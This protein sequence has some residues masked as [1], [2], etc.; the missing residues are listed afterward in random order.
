LRK[1]AR[2]ENDVEIYQNQKEIIQG[3]RQ[4]RNQV[5]EE[6]K[7]IEL[8]MREYRQVRENQSMGQ[9]TFKVHQEV[10]KKNDID[11]KIRNMEAMEQMA[12][13]RLRQTEMQTQ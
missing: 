6:E 8:K 3:K 11:L 9:H 13:E 7:K 1:K 10:S 4:M 5:K 2:N 12:L